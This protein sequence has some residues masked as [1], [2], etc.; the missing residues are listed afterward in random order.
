MKER[1]EI[2]QDLGGEGGSARGVVD[3]ESG[4]VAHDER[5]GCQGFGTVG[6]SFRQTRNPCPQAV[7]V[8]QDEHDGLPLFRVSHRPQSEEISEKSIPI[9][10]DALDHSG[11]WFFRNEEVQQYVP[12]S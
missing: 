11:G 3:L 2:H 6:A 7:F 8:V 1:V 10:L 9:L 5:I 12:P 4:L